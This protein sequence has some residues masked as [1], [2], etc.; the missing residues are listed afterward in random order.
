METWLFILGYLIQLCGS[1]MLFWKIWRKRSVYGLSSDTQYCFGLSTLSRAIWSLETR[2]VSTRLAYVELFLSV[3]VS[4]VLCWAV[5]R[6]RHTTTKEALWYLRT[7]VLAPTAFFLAFFWHPGKDVISMQILVAFTMYVECLAL[8]P[9]LYLMRR[10]IEIEPLT[11]HYVAAV[12]MSRAVRLLFWLVMYRQRELF[13]G[14][15]FADLIHSILAAD[16]MFLWFRKLRTGG[17]L[18]YQF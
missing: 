9:Q 15:F 14:L 18:I 12:G 10:M 8:L 6:F 13:W 1:L 17:T 11:S 5:Y 7:Q 3:S 4:L 16:Y 2:L